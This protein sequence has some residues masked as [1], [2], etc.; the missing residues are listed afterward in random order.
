MS[1]GAPLYEP[2]KPGEVFHAVCFIQYRGPKVHSLVNAWNP[3]DS[4]VKDALRAD[5][6]SLK[7]PLVKADNVQRGKR[8]GDIGLEI[9]WRDQKCSSVCVSPSQTFIVLIGCTDAACT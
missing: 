9:W 3:K 4:L 1:A 7:V 6:S 5:L 8:H 2:R